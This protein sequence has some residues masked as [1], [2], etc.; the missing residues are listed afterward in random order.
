MK[1]IF[2]NLENEYFLLSKEP[3]IFAAIQKSKLHTFSSL[4]KPVSTTKAKGKEISLKSS[5]NMMGKLLLSVRSREIDLKEVLSFSLGPYPLS[6]A[7]TDGIM[8]KTVK[9]NLMHINEDMVD[10][11][12]TDVIPSNGALIIDAMAMFQSLSQ[13]PA[14]FEELPPLLLSILISMATRLNATSFYRK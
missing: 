14:T 6:L 9:A 5:R 1:D 3:D 10:D 7:T 11:S 12:V 2:G 8:V 4:T 13:V